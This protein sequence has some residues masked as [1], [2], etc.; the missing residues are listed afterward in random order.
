MPFVRLLI[1]L[2][3]GIILGIQLE[4]SLPIFVPFLLWI[5]VLLVYFIQKYR[6]KFHQ[7]QQIF[8]PIFFMILSCGWVLTDLQLSQNKTIKLAEKSL[9]IASITETPKA[10]EN[11][12]AL[13]VEIESY[14][15]NNQWYKT[16]GNAIVYLQKDSIA[17]RLSSGMLIGFQPKFDDIKNSGNPDEFNY[18]NYMAY[19]LISSQTYLKSGSWILI[20]GKTAGSIKLWFLKLRNQL[21]NIYREAGLQNNEYAVAAAL[22]LGYKDQLQDKLK[23]AYAS[24]GAMHILAVSGLHIGIIFMVMQFLLAGFKKIKY[25]KILQVCIL[26]AS[27]WFY[28]MLTGLSPSVTRAATMFTFIS[29]GKFFKRHVNIY[30]ILAASAFLTLVI[31][32]L[33]LTELGFWL[34]YL[35]VLSIVL[36]FQPI[37]NLWQPKYKLS[38]KIWSLIA[39]SMAVQIGTVPLTVFYF[40][41]FS[42]YFILTNLL[43]IPLVTIIVFTAIALFVFSFVPMVKLLLGKLLT[44]VISLL[45]HSVFWIESLPFSVSENLYITRMQMLILFAAIFAFSIYFLAHKRRAVFPALI[46]LILFISVGILRHIENQ[47]DNKFIVYNLPKNSGINFILGKENIL[48]TDF[49]SPKFE[50]SKSKLKNHWLAEGIEKEKF[51]DLNKLSSK[52]MLT[53]LISIS[54]PALF[55]KEGF[56]AYK[57]FRVLI[58]FDNRYNNISTDQKLPLDCIVLSNNAKIDLE[59]INQCFNFKY[60]ILDSSNT[61]YYCQKIKEA[62]NKYKF[63]T[64]DVNE[65]GAF[66]KEL[67]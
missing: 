62:S 60:L 41:Q 28:A 48:F 7:S 39:V 64:F 32:P 1:P 17:E 56:V 11:A 21:L 42:N 25:L 31:N 53:N 58:I 44:I 15:H 5:V 46:L 6:P 4:Y 27:I 47:T 51:I 50:Q 24:S 37:Y 18:S 63:I 45:N 40:H 35:A 26:I 38:D 2:I 61:F 9:L 57:D 23:H 12:I 52:F 36:F 20:D 49:Q 65:K 13:Q 66:L 54:H 33:N 10:I 22:S 16:E 8:L 59:T 14:K 30:N 3:S 67:Y 34:S 29:F 43:V 19:H 55:Q